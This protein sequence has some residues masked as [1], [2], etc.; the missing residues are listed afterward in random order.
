M[1]KKILFF[2]W[3]HL[4]WSAKPISRWE[5]AIEILLLAIVVIV[6][7]QM[8]RIVILQRSPIKPFLCIS[9]TLLALALAGV[10]M[11]NAAR[12]MNGGK[13]PTV[14]VWGY[15]VE[16]NTFHDPVSF[17]TKFIYGAN[18]IKVDSSPIVASLF[19]GSDQVSIGD[20]IIVATFIV[21]SWVVVVLAFRIMILFFKERCVLW[22]Q[23]PRR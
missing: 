11:N 21:M 5:M 14:P 10:S 6:R 15:E 3:L 2:P 4:H 20:L 18:F 22:K 7:W 23:K 16:H 12:T 17:R 1:I 9:L 19:P 8:K 13:M